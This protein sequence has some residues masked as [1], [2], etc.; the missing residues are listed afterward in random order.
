[1]TPADL[2][3]TVLRAVLAAVAEG[4]LPHQAEGEEPRVQRP[5]RPGHGDYASSIALRLAKATGRPARELAEVIAKRLAEQPGIA[6]VEVAEPGFLNITLDAGTQD[7]QL[8]RVFEQ[9]SRYGSEPTALAGQTVHLAPAREQRAQLLTDT[10]IRLLRAQGAQAGTRPGAPE[11]L[12]VVPVK[13]DPT[14]RLG[15]DETRWALLRP[16]A[17]DHPHLPPGPEQRESNALFRIQYAHARACALARNA[18]DLGIGHDGQCGNSAADERAQA[19]RQALGDLPAAVE[20]AARLRAPDRLARHL[21]Q[22]AEA[23]LR[24]IAERPPLP[25]G[26]EE[27]TDDHRGRLRLIAAARITLANGLGLLGLT[28]PEHL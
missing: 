25:R 11:A 24:F 17:H 21:E 15:Q 27:V 23:L 13:E 22:L 1:M 9:G 12:Q 20:S 8:T 26:D 6:A 7:D 5:P 18:A 16:A 10:V 14:P 3:R 2:S 28:A 4:E 19:L